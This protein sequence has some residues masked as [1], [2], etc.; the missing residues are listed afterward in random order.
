MATTTVV[1]VSTSFQQ[2]VELPRAIAIVEGKLVKG[3]KSYTTKVI[4]K[5]YEDVTASVVSNSLKQEW[6]PDTVVLEGMF[7]IHITPWSIHKNLGDY[8]D[9]L[10]KQHILPH[11]QNM[12]REVHLLFDNTECQQLSPQYFE[13]QHWDLANQV[14]DDHSLLH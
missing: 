4:E 10:I 2:C 13:R 6:I 14:P 8:A 12:S 5:R 1:A 7:L 3:S 9:F 11:F